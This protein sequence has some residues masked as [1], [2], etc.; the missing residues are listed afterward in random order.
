MTTDP[1]ASVS[2]NPDGGLTIG[3][4]TNVS[5]SD[6]GYVSSSDI[7]FEEAGDGGSAGRLEIANGGGIYTS[8]DTI[9][10]NAG[11]EESGLVLTRLKAPS[12]RFRLA[13]R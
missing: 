10:D 7:T 9:L 13:E 4:G 2:P 5:V 3:S 6:G 8:V 12:L 1:D 11:N